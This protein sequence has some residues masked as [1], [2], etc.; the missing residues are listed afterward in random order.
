MPGPKNCLTVGQ[1]IA[2]GQIIDDL[3]GR[4]FTFSRGVEIA[5]V[6][7]CAPSSNI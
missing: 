6:L 4:C 7:K 5:S 2:A 3:A 1:Q